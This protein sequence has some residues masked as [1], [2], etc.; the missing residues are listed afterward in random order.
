[1][2]ITSS[3]ERAAL[4]DVPNAYPYQIIFETEKC[5][6]MIRQ[7]MYSSL[8][9]RIS[10]RPFLEIIEKRW[11]A[12]QLLCALRDCHAKGVHHGDIKSENVLVTS[13]NWI[14]LA[15]FASFKPTY[16]PAD[17]PADFS[18]YF[19]T[20]ARRICYVAP[21]RFLDAGQKKEDEVLTDSMD[22]FSLG[23]VIAEL[24]LEGT[25]MFTLSQLFKYRSGE[26]DPSPQLAKIEDQEIRALVRHMI[27]LDPAQRCSAEQYLNDWRR[28]AFPEY[29]YSFLHQYLS[30]ITDP[31]SVKGITVNDQTPTG[32]PDERI[33]RIYHDFDKIAF[34]LGYDQNQDSVGEERAQ[35]DIFPLNL[36]IPN[37][38]RHNSAIR[39]R[40]VSLDDGTL[41]FLSLIASSLRNTSRATARVRACDIILAFAER[42]TDEAKMN[43][44]LPY[45]IM[46]MNDRSI[47]VQVASMRAVA[48]LV[49]WDSA[50]FD[51]TR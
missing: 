16:L 21:E 1:M 26:Y 28:K 30:F 44:C 12:F 29:F 2:L 35:D 4:E 27:S 51:R 40:S 23:C 7:Y 42:I 45:L 24:F 33:D 32:L 38:Q 47:S 36:D 41:I 19:D 43:R 50:I 22:V 10:T 5:G 39:K 20:S 3:G 48:Q 25:P 11:I 37:Y 17:N 18:Y 34:F 8:Y 14:F 15:D 9:D 46:L 6:Y 31:A 49:R 13:W